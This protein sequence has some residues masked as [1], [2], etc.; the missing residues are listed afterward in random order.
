[1]KR[2][3]L[4]GVLILTGCAIGADAAHLL[5]RSPDEFCSEATWLVATGNYNPFQAA[6]ILRRACV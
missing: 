3:L 5:I 6:R 1:M 2:L 4:V